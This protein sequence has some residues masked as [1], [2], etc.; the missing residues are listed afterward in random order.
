MPL[1]LDFSSEPMQAGES[2]PLIL[3][4]KLPAEVKIRCFVNSPPPGY[5]PCDECG[6]FKI[7]TDESV[8][9]YAGPKVFGVSGGH[10]EIEVRDSSGQ[11]KSIRLKVFRLDEA[12]AGTLEKEEVKM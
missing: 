10:L 3:R 1:E 11:I 4:S 2:R 5:R 9:I 8:M 12:A 7:R 6:T